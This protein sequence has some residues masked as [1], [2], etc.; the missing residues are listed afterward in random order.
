MPSAE[1]VTKEQEAQQQPGTEL[2]STQRN[3]ASDVADLWYD[4][5][6]SGQKA[7]LEALRD[8]VNLA[9][10]MQGGKDSKR[11]KLI[12]GAFA[13]ADR[14]GAAPLGMMAGAIRGATVFYVDVAVNVNTDVDAFRDVN[15]GVSV[16]TDVDVK[17]ML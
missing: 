3:G 5:A 8:F 6:R 4:F 1:A 10:P 17:G 2:V 16:P 7:T 12:D 9:V 11:R 13:I 15:V 14:A